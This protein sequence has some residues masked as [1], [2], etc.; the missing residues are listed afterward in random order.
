ME[1][2][3]RSDQ[4]ASEIEQPISQPRSDERMDASLAFMSEGIE[5]LRDSH[6]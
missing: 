1:Q 4:P 2:E 5:Q 6:C 3:N